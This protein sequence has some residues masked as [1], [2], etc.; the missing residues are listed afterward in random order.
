LIPATKLALG[1]AQFGLD[2]GVFNRTGARVADDVAAGILA[3]AAANGIDTLDTARAY[4]ESEAV[5]GRVRA[6]ERFRIVTK[7]PALRGGGLV[8]ASGAFNDSLAALGVSSVAGLMFH[9]ADDL[10]GPDGPELWKFAETLR[11]RA[12]VD[13]I[14]VSIYAPEQIFEIIDRFPPDIVQL[15]Y[16]VFDQRFACSGALDRLADANI[17]VH[18]RSVFLQ[19]LALADPAALPSRFERFR[20]ELERLDAACRE[21]GADRITYALAHVLMDRRISRAVVGC[22][23][24]IQLAGIVTAASNPI[25]KT[26]FSPSKDMVLIDPREWE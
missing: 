13:R 18:A 11:D 19:G 15:P 3:Y 8:A 4:G 20:S 1:T 14:G 7:I 25:I 22:E 16:N 24:Q 23:S 12:K 17:E 6:G 21:W 10:L 9:D 2:Y 5:L 26:R